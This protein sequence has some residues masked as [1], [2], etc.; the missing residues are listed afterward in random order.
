MILA[1]NEHLKLISKLA[2]FTVI[3][4]N[5]ITSLEEEITIMKLKQSILENKIELLNK[6]V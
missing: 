1:I 3:L 6:R 5:R 2:D 4:A